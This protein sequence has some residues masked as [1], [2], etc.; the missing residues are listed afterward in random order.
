MRP[1]TGTVVLVAG[2]FAG[3]AGCA[4]QAA[5]PPPK[6]LDTLIA[7]TDSINPSAAGTP[8]RVDL[9]IFQLRAATAFTES[10]L[11]ALY[12]TVERARSALGADLLQTRKLQ[13]APA[14][15]QQVEIQLDDQARYIGVLAAFEQ[16]G[17]ARWKDIVEVRDEQLKDKLLLRSRQLT[18]A[19]DRLSV[20][21]RLD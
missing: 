5:E 17:Q 8:Q 4:N 9:M 20:E 19:L 13:I 14:V 10:Q 18:I 3:L 21:L 7:A 16:F 15:E 11:T 2:V 6:P 1:L 12:P